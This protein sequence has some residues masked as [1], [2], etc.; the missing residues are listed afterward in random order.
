MTNITED[1]ELEQL[2][3]GLPAASQ[4][5]ILAADRAAQELGEHPERKRWLKIGAGLADVRA[6]ALR[7]ANTESL[8]HPTYRKYHRLIL[9]KVPA[10]AEREKKDHSSCQNAVWMFNNWQEVE[11]FLSKIDDM[12]VHNRLN[13]PTT[14]KRH[15]DAHKPKPTI[16]ERQARETVAQPVSRE[17]VKKEPEA[18]NEPDI[19][20]STLSMM[21]QQRFD[22]AMRQHKR[23]L[24]I[25]FQGRVDSEVSKRLEK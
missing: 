21:A 17:E 20:P 10:L 18:K 1:E 25:E 7:L 19:D 22:A 23:K 8:Q 24:D 16:S 11:G 15:Y 3:E 5:S 9:S 14:I 13:N 12:M 2:W 4:L 6:E